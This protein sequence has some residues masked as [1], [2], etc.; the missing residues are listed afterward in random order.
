[1]QIIVPSQTT[2]MNESIKSFLVNILFVI[3]QS[4]LLSIHAFT[5]Y[6]QISSFADKG[7]N[8]AWNLVIIILYMFSYI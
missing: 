7:K 3:P 6:D 1:M 5:D 2:D 4:G 8:T